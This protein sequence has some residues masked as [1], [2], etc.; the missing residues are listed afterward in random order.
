MMQISLVMSTPT[1]P[2]NEDTPTRVPA[3]CHSSR[4]N[5]WLA[6]HSSDVLNECRATIFRNTFQCYT[7]REENAIREETRRAQLQKHHKPYPILLYNG[8]L[9]REE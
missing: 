9:L 4:D 7:E 3:N 8:G 2:P 1:T 6:G 5:Y